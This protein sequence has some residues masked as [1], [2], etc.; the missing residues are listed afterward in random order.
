MWSA[1]TIEWIDVE[2]TSFC[3]IECPGC[4]RQVKNNKVNSI[5]NSDFLKFENLKKWI[6]IDDFPNLNLINFCGSIDEP[7]L[8]PEILDIVDYFSK[9]CNINIS[10]N[11]STKTET[12]W[13]ELGKYKISVFFGIDG[14]DQKSLEKYRIGSNFKKIQR[15]YRA[16]IDAGGQATWQFIVFDHNEHLIDEAMKISKNEGFNN[17][18]KVYSHRKGNQESKKIKKKESKEIFCKYGNQKRLFLNHTGALLPCCF[19]NSEFLQVYSGNEPR[20]EF[21]YKYIEQGGV[22][23]NNLKYISPNEIINGELFDFIIKSWKNKPISRCLSTCKKTNQ[24]VFIDEG[25]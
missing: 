17:F 6:T 23:C 12:F 19:F 1:S 18:R 11:G 20:T 14:I 15:N 16:F 7:T 3:N 8:H 22:L 10:S 5:L 13:K 21:D 24:D 2:L 25:L 4:F 9:I